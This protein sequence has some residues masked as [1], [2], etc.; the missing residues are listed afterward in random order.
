MSYTA[1]L[2]SEGVQQETVRAV[3]DKLF[4]GSS[5][6]L[7]L[8]LIE[9]DALTAK[10][11]KACANCWTGWPRN[12]RARQGRRRRQGLLTCQGHRT[13]Q[14]RRRRRMLDSGHA[15]GLFE[16]FGR[17]V[18]DLLWLP[19]LEAL[20]LG[21]LVWVLLFVNP[22]CPARIRHFLWLLVLPNAGD[23]R[24]ALAWTVR[25]SVGVDG[26]PWRTRR[27]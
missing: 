6:S 2:K 23:P 5:Q 7:V 12:L 8:H 22:G 18:V 26:E 14:G 9:S 27:G 13:C 4:A 25:N 10:K 3:V 19:S 15:I 20:L 21:V 24:T 1:I 11:P 16:G 17:Q